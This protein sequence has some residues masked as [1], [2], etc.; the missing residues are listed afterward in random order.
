MKLW[1]SRTVAHGARCR[2]MCGCVTLQALNELEYPAK[3]QVR[4]C[5]AKVQHTDI[6]CPAF[7][8]MCCLTYSPTR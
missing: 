5:S 7:V 2:L 3:L 1:C 6:G 4:H 8:V